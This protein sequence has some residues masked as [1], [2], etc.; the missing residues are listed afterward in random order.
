ME[1]SMGLTFVQAEWWI[2]EL[3]KK[4]VIKRTNKFVQKI[5][6]GQKYVIYKYIK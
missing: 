6:K 4:N 5:G 2:K 3:V 1:S